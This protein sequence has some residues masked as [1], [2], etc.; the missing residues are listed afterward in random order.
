MILL[1]CI[2]WVAWLGVAVVASTAWRA[3]AE[4]R[5]ID[6]AARFGVAG[7]LDFARG[8]VYDIAVAKVIGGAV[9]IIAVAYLWKHRPPPTRRESHRFRFG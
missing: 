5:R 9:V 8:C 3:V 4:H 6:A 1:D 7:A 2:Y